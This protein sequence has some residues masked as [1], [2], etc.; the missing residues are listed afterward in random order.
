VSHKLLVPLHPAGYC[1]SGRA[2]LFLEGKPEVHITAGQAY[3]VP[4]GVRHHW[5][6]DESLEVVEACAPIPFV[7]GRDFSV[8]PGV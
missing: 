6:V 1:V 5:K 3:C 7:K 8:K 4:T 2:R